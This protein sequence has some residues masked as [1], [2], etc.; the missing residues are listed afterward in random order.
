LIFKIEADE[1]RPSRQIAELLVEH[2]EIPPEQRDLFLKVARQEKTADHLGSL[3]PPSTSQPINASQSVQQP[4]PAAL[5]RTSLPLPLTPIIGR[6]HELHAIIQQLQNPACR[7]LTLTGP[8]GVGKTRLAIEVAHRLNGSFNHGSYFVSLVGT[9]ASELIVPAIADV[10]GFAFTGTN[11]LNKQLSNY[12]KEKQ[13]LLVLDNLEHLLNGIQ[14]LDE[15]LEGAPSVK[16][17]ATSREQLNL[18]A[19]WAFE[20]QGLPVR[21]LIE[22]KDMESNSAVAL[23]IQRAK[24]MKLDYRPTADDLASIM[25]ICQLVEGLPLGL[26]LAAAWVKIMSV[27]EIAREIERSMDFLRTTARD[28][29][30]RHRSIRAVFEHSWSLL[31][32]GER[33]VM[34]RLSIFRGFTRDA[35]EKVAG[36]TLP[37][38][39]S[40]MDKSILRQSA[41]NRYY[42]HELLRQYAASHLEQNA[43]EQS[44]ILE[45]Y[46][47]YYLTLLEQRDP[48][49]RSN[50]Q[51][52]TLVELTAD[53]DNLRAAWEIAVVYKRIELIQ[54][55]A[56]SLWYYY[57]LRDS[58][59]EGEAAFERAAAMCQAQLDIMSPSHAERPQLE[60]ALGELLSHQAQFTFRQGRV[61]EAAALYQ[62]SIRLLRPLAEPSALTHAL[63]YSGVVSWI[64]GRFED[65]WSSL[66]EALSIAQNMGDGWAQ[67]Q[68]LNFM[69]MVAHAQ[70]DY[71]KAYDF[72]K[73]SIA[74]ARALGDVR[75]ISFISGQLS[76]AAQALGRTEEVLDL[77]NESLRLATETGDRLGMGS[78]LEQLAV[79]TRTSG[80]EKEAR[81]LLK[82]SI[83]QFRDIGD[84]WFLGHA[85]NLEGYFA[86]D[87]GEDHQAR[88]SF[89]QAVKIA[90]ENQS[91]PNVLG[92]LAGLAALDVKDGRH[93]QALEMT[94]FVLAHPAGTQETRSRAEKLRAE[95]EAQLTPEQ[96]QMA[97]S[98]A[99]S[100]TLDSLMQ[101]LSG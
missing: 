66:S 89:G 78:T 99:R 23:F 42:L 97:Q 43:D 28:M 88:E 72:L 33:Y 47:R 4:S 16:I 56:F 52:Q 22:G 21:S 46:C 82:E 50:R 74:R 38:L 60:G 80:D 68:C 91:P 40:L 29:P 34:M 7:L 61:P 6:E 32:E 92:A 58:L 65:A 83:K 14:L 51:K 37:I 85:L 90:F 59:K 45:K 49:M 36:A 54:R 20:I 95:L 64:G 69:G 73:D 25:R 35:A 94:L 101:D 15:L 9:R 71:F 63:T 24:Q 48:A 86:L 2:L 27:N 77:L 70:G 100:M 13:V 55:A 57:N 18:R 11:E 3:P 5:L 17:L 76:R 10:L 75:F 87:T 26:E 1:R 53:I 81:H 8:G 79:A 12:L 30:V 98:R 62:A 67:A 44:A 31:L 19:E 39:S 84:M 96:I 93:E 41:I